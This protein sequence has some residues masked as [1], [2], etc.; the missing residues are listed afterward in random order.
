MDPPQSD[1]RRGQKKERRH[2]GDGELSRGD[3]VALEQRARVSL[4]NAVRR[5]R[6]NAAAIRSDESA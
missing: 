2:G 5:R 4:T 1:Q 3:A 6:A